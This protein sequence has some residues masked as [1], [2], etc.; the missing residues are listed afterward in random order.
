MKIAYQFKFAT[1]KK[2]KLVEKVWKDFFI[3]QQLSMYL[4][5]VE[6]LCRM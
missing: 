2:K 6:F 3:V 1:F 5:F 4:K